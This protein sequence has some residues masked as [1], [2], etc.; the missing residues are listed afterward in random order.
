MFDAGPN[1]AV[2]GG[3]DVDDS[4]AEEEE[5]QGC[6]DETFAAAPA[7]LPCRG[8]TLFARHARYF[9]LPFLAKFPSAHSLSSACLVSLHV[10]S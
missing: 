8:E 9:S 6:S 3:G 7:L 10:L 4:Q 5:G 1:C 2:R